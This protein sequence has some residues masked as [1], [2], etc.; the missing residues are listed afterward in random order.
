MA[1]DKYG[2]K[3]LTLTVSEEGKKPRVIDLISYYYVENDTYQYINRGAERRIVVEFS[4]NVT[5][6]LLRF[7]IDKLNPSKGLKRIFQKMVD[8]NKIVSGE[9]WDDEI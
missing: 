9:Y 4:K 8:D 1:D 3:F 2:Y 5:I 7:V 6:D